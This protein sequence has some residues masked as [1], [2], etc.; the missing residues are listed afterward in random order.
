MSDHL[1]VK[2]VRYVA[3]RTETVQKNEYIFKINFNDS[4]TQSFMTQLK[5]FLGKRLFLTIMK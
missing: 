5:V 2:H 1:P 3:T 4:S